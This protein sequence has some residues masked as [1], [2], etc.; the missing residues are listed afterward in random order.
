MLLFKWLFVFILLTTGSFAS[1][2]VTV[3]H[4]DLN[5]YLG[6]WYEIARFEAWFETGCVNV[7][8]EYSKEDNLIKVVNTCHLNTLNGKFK[9]STGRAWVVDKKTNAKLKVSFT[10]GYLSF[11]DRFFSGDYWILKL[12]PNYEVAMV[13]EPS[14]KYL[15]ILARTST[16]DHSIYEEYVNYARDLGF[17]ISKLQLVPQERHN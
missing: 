9:S 10:P 11:L 8:A 15:W 3:Q 12:D 6:K 4:V 2:M 7:T 14:K 5:K 13:G 17:D 1:A 16:I